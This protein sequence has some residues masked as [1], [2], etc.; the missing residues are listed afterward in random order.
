[1]NLLN[2]SDKGIY[3]QQGDFY[4]DPWKP[5][6]RAVITHAH[7]DHAR[8]G[9]ASYLCHHFTKPL[10]QLRLGE[11]SVQSVGWKE[12]VFINGVKVSLHPVCWHN[13]RFIPIQR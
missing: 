8:P 12:P 4:I 9:N 7:S 6:D 10:L 1:M 5:V 3:C 11:I 2:F 13:Y